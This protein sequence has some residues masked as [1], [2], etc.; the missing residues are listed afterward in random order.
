ML[1]LRGRISWLGIAGEALRVQDYCA[2]DVRGTCF[3]VGWNEVRAKR[4]FPCFLFTLS[5]NCLLKS[6]HSS[7]HFMEIDHSKQDTPSI[8]KLSP[9][10][11]NDM[12]KNTS[13]PHQNKLLVWIIFRLKSWNVK[14]LSFHKAKWDLMP[15][16]QVSLQQM[17]QLKL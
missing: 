15:V 11:Q 16:Y 6:G 14:A 8:W 4:H 2:L 12:P 13:P 1:P 9:F 17:T 3:S 5:V 7:Q 10:S